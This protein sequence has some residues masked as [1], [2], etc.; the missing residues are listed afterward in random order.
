[1]PLAW[2]S[3]GTFQETSSHNLS[4]NI[5]PQSSQLTK[6]LWTDLSLKN[7]INVSKL[8]STLK[9]KA[10]VEHEWSNLLPKFLASKEKATTTT[11]N[12][13][14]Q[15]KSMMGGNRELLRFIT[16]YAKISKAHNGIR[17]SSNLSPP[18]D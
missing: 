13:S 12:H 5:W 17:H 11:G 7:G 9:K 3:V 2:H 16:D 8:T 15:D 14:W 10:Q 1:M 18:S 6:P 4:G